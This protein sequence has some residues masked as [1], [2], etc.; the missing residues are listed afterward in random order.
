MLAIRCAFI[1][2]IPGFG[3]PVFG[4][5]GRNG[6]LVWSKPGNS[7]RTFSY[8]SLSIL[9]LSARS[10]PPSSTSLFSAVGGIGRNF[11]SM[12]RGG[13]ERYTG[14][15]WRGVSGLLVVKLAK[16][17]RFACNRLETLH[18]SVSGKAAGPPQYRLSLTEQSLD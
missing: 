7:P 6:S 16:Y 1:A 9:S 2:S 13:L 5:G 3:P 11:S 18:L 14:T 12:F 17:W 10:A 4:A 15:F 8:M